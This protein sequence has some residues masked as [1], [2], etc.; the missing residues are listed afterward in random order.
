MAL[1]TFPGA[2]NFGTENADGT[3]GHFCKNG[4]YEEYPNLQGLKG[5]EEEEEEGKNRGDSHRDVGTT[6]Y[7]V[8]EDALAEAL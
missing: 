2:Q 5:H 4:A 6:F 8:E 1:E 7:E 3:F